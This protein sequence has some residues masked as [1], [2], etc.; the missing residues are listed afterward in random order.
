MPQT[1]GAIATAMPPQNDATRQPK[2]LRTAP[3]AKVTD[4]LQAIRLIEKLVSTGRPTKEET[5]AW[6]AIKNAVII[7]KEDEAGT[8]GRSPGIVEIREELAKVH[9]AITKLTDQG[10]HNREPAEKNG[11]VNR[12]YAAVAG[13]NAGLNQGRVLQVPQRRGREV[14]ISPGNETDAQRARTGLQ[15]VRDLQAVTDEAIAVRRLPRGAVVVTFSTE[16]NKREWEGKE[17][18]RTVFGHEAKI[19]VRSLDVIVPRMRYQ[20]FETEN[21]A[22]AIREVMAQNPRF[23]GSIRKLHWM[24]RSPL[25]QSNHGPLIVGVDTAEQGNYMISQGLTWNGELFDAEVFSGSVKATRCFN[26]QQYGNHTARNCKKQTRCG[27]CAAA[28]H[29]ADQCL[30]AK[31]GQF[32]ACAPCNG[33]KGHTAT[34]RTCPTKA[35][36]EA[37]ARQAYLVR[38]TSFQEHNLARKTR[39]TA[40]PPPQRPSTTFN[41]S[42]ILPEID[43]EP[44]YTQVE[45]TNKR[46]RGRP[47]A[48]NVPD[49]TPTQSIRTFLAPQTAFT[50]YTQPVTTQISLDQSQEVATT[51][52]EQIQ[53]QLSALAGSPL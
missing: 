18:L 36:E 13:N 3:K 6:G 38:P 35:R 9:R 7:R 34:D 16:E 21:Q 11:P 28:G 33:R 45:S 24:K 46:R 29:S 44:E 32:K 17:T 22:K 25:N 26:C 4:L 20:A 40:P 49:Q 12:S 14:I 15:L 50:G 10:N 52:A 31:E 39:E 2:N 51:E 5:E 8:K 30:A 23:K 43:L 19:V 41:G 42:E 53:S 27:H 1:Q 47:A 37:K 48:V